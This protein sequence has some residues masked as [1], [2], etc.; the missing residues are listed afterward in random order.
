MGNS[1]RQTG[2][3]CDSPACEQVYQRH[4]DAVDVE[5]GPDDTMVLMATDPLVERSFDAYVRERKRLE[6]EKSYGCH[7]WEI[8]VI[9]IAI[10]RLDATLL[11][12][13]LT[14][15]LALPYHNNRDDLPPRRHPTLPVQLPLWPTFAAVVVLH[16][17]LSL[18]WTLGVRVRRYGFGLPALS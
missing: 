2:S 5:A 6:F 4:P 3:F 7:L 15:F 12:L 11:N 16:W 14:L 18:I 8:P 1:E 10:W 9:I 13:T 17:L